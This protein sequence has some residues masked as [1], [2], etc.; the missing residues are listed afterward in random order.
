[1]MYES[2]Q[3]LDEYKL[4]CGGRMANPYPIYHRPRCEDPVHWIDLANS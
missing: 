2:D 4:I 3:T 1:M